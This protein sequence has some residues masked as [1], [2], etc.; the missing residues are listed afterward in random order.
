M[1]RLSSGHR[2]VVYAALFVFIGYA[3]FISLGSLE[4]FPDGL[5]VDENMPYLT[6]KP[7]GEDGY[8]MLTVAWNTVGGDFFSYNY[9]QKT[10]GIQPLGTLIYSGLASVVQQ[11]GGDKWSFVRAVIFLGSILQVIFAFLIGRISRSFFSEGKRADMAFI[12][13]AGVALLNFD[14]FRAFT[15]GLETGFYLIGIASCVLWTLNREYISLTESVL[16]G[17]LVGIT[18]LIRIDFGLIFAVLIIA[19]LL[20]RRISFVGS[21]ISGTTALAVVSPWFMWVHHVTGDWLPSSGTAQGSMIG[22]G[23]AFGRLSTML[24][25]VI[26]HATPWMYTG[27]WASLTIVAVLSLG[28]A[29]I[30]LYALRSSGPAQVSKNASMTCTAWGFTTGLLIA[31]YPVFFWATHFYG[32][33][34][35]PILVVLLPGLVVL[36]VR[37]VDGEYFSWVQY[38]VIPGLTICF[39][40]WAGASL[41]TGRIGNSH[42]V[43]AGFIEEQVPSEYK[44]GAFQSGVIGFYHPNAVNLDGKIDHRALPHLEAG[45]MEKYVDQQGIDVL[46]D[47]KGALNRFKET[48]LEAHWKPC[49]PKIPNGMSFCRIRKPL[50]SLSTS[51]RGRSFGPNVEGYYSW[52]GFDTTNTSPS[53]T[54]NQSVKSRISTVATTACGRVAP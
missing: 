32:R 12:L 30:V 19:F 38:L 47:W 37:W 24:E 21:I 45:T 50:P 49:G 53:P 7:V 29:G 10:T 14:V 17:G 13:G 9:G 51:K 8:Y 34:T 16:F 36:A 5:R 15:Y 52:G 42:A 27:S 28:V 18:G 39:L 2:R 33:Y 43:S 3:A 1:Y 31:V 41:H 11:F 40:V 23:N 35:A 22:E 20:Q 4:G 48:Y 26:N 25:A 54:A 6:D 44:V 46:I